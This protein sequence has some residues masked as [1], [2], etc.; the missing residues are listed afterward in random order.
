MLLS[1]S[2]FAGS[3]VCHEKNP[4]CFEMQHQCDDLTECEVEEMENIL[5]HIP[6]IPSF[7]PEVAFSKPNFKYSHIFIREFDLSIDK[8]PQNFMRV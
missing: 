4:T 5:T 3:F 8:P 2:S 1:F 6:L 7:G